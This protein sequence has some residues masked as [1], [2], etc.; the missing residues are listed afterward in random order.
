MAITSGLLDN[1]Y[2]D[3]AL[4]HALVLAEAGT[5]VEDKRIGSVACCFWF[6]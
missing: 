2:L 4:S 5:T 6:R 1:G 3:F